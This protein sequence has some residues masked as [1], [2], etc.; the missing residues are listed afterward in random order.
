MKGFTYKP[1]TGVQ[2]S[3]IPAIFGCPFQ[4]ISS[5]GLKTTQTTKKGHDDV[6]QTVLY[7]NCNFAHPVSTSRSDIGCSVFSKV[8]ERPGMKPTYENLLNFIAD[9][10]WFENYMIENGGTSLDE[11]RSVDVLVTRVREETKKLT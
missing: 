9:L 4:T 8:K 11:Y 5:F 2:K 3:L 1:K 10:R 6:R 7:N